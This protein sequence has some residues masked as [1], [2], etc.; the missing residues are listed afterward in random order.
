MKQETLN[1]SPNRE[2]VDEQSLS[3]ID[4]TDGTGTAQ[5]FL[6]LSMLTLSSIISPTRGPSQHIWRFSNCLKYIRVSCQK[7]K[8]K[9][10]LQRCTPVP[11]NLKCESAS[12][13]ISSSPFQRCLCT[14]SKPAHRCIWF[15]IT[16]MPRQCVENIICFLCKPLIHVRVR[17]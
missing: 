14:N 15:R 8:K 6:F 17:R 13:P 1:L 12:L 2:Y 4:F 5:I 10:G 3:E 16:Y 7:K 11:R 9:K